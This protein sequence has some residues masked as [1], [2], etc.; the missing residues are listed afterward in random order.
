M[1]AIILSAGQGRRLLPLT[2]EK[3][4]AA[5][6][7]G[8]RTVLEWQLQEIGR[9]AVDEVVV[10]TGFGADHIDRIVDTQ[11]DVAA[12]TLYNPFFARCDNLGTCW[13]ARHEMDGPFIVVNGDTLF[14][15]AV[16]ER[17]LA[18]ASGAPITLVTDSKASYDEDDMK[19]IVSAGRLQR[20]GKRLERT[21]ISGESI[22]MMHFD[23]AGAVRFR[24]QIEHMM[25]Y[26]T[27]LEQWYLAA[28]DALAREDIVTT[29]PI[30]GLSW[31]EIDTQDDL[32]RAASVVA[33]WYRDNETRASIGA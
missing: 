18:N 17:L 27:G 6:P 25:R 24:A 30:D 31:S 23:A 1:K 16:L 14:E 2:S 29:C 9:C 21:D 22:G 20:V 33:G 26:G 15:S 5:L 19:V 12:R 10:V 28:I 13:V 7:V 4:K 3:P 11:R 8:D 32:M